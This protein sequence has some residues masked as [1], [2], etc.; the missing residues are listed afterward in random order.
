M[1]TTKTIDSNVTS[2]YI[3]E[4]DDL[5]ILPSN[6]VWHGIEVNSYSDF[7]G[8]TTLLQRETI[9]PSRQ[10]QK[11]KI[12]DIDASAGFS[13]DMTKNIFPWLMRG[14]MFAEAREKFTTQSLSGKTLP[15]KSVSKGYNFPD[16]HKLPQKLLTGTIIHASG[17]SNFANNGL[18][19]VS[20]CSDNN[21]STNSST[22]QI[23]ELNPPASAKISAVGFKF[24]SGS[25]SME[26]KKG[27]LPKLVSTSTDLTKLGLIEGEWIW[28]G[29]DASDSYFPKNRGWARITEITSKQ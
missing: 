20:S 13:L 3:A 1:N 17:F 9:N 21:I 24:S 18:K 2:L 7:G 27:T 23:E 15:I 6:P 26:V 19:I 5:K 25:C 8:S 4:E 12:V 22:P 14:F 11:G 28:V 16:S 29:G 10:N